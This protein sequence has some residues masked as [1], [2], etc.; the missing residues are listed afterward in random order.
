MH[1]RLEHVAPSNHH[2]R[3]FMRCAAKQGKLLEFPVHKGIGD[4]ARLVKEMG[5]TE[6]K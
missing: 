4:M 3:S 6:S 1:D 2:C 5:I